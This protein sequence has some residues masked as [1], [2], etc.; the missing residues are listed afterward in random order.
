MN[1]EILLRNTPQCVRASGAHPISGKVATPM[2]K[3][4]MVM[5]K[6]TN[7]DTV[8]VQGVDRI[9]PKHELVLANFAANVTRRGYMLEREVKSDIDYGTWRDA[10]RRR[11]PDEANHY[12]GE[13]EPV[14]VNSTVAGRQVEEIEVEGATYLDASVT[15]LLPGGTN[16]TLVN[17]KWALVSS[18]AN[19]GVAGR[20]S[21]NIAPI[22][23][24]NLFRY[25][26]EVLS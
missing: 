2:P 24:A 8:E 17:G 21:G 3:G 4:I 5:R 14:K 10:S 12:L 23:A 6:A 9:S 18:Y 25:K 15:G 26:I 7:A 16:L 19:Y 22:V 11:L 13:V 1:P 20:I